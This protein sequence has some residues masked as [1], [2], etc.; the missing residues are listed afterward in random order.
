MNDRERPSLYSSTPFTS[1]SPQCSGRSPALPYPPGEHIYYNCSGYIGKGNS[2]NLRSRNI[3]I[4]RA[5]YCL[6]L[7]K[8]CL[9]NGV[10]HRL[11]IMAR[12]IIGSCVVGL[13]PG[14]LNEWRSDPT[15]KSQ[16]NWR[17]NSRL[18]KTS[19]LNLRT[20]W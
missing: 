2:Q 17:T 16:S 5:I 3:N 19:S 6:T 7:P 10:H 12:G 20:C 8:V 14:L 18:L 1:H 11:L 15:G 13:L 4:Q 9:D